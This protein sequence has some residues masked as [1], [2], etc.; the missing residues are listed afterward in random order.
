MRTVVLRG[1]GQ[2]DR[3]QWSI[4]E[5]AKF[6]SYLVKMIDE[7]QH[8]SSSVETLTAAI[9]DHSRRSFIFHCKESQ[10]FPNSSSLLHTDTGFSQQPFSPFSGGQ[11]YWSWLSC[12][13][14]WEEFGNSVIY[15]SKTKDRTH[16]WKQP[17]LK[18]T[19]L[20]KKNKAPNKCWHKTE[21][22]SEHYSDENDGELP[23]KTVNVNF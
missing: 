18:K 20:K 21:N 1:T 15:Y 19:S 23:K 2:E 4:M 7:C 17:S 12:C 6:S 10:V 9:R 3:G 11:I 14:I 5:A 22:C 13:L 8:C 16:T